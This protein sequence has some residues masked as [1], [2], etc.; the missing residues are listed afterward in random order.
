[1]WY[2]K[3]SC[4]VFIS[5]THLHGKTRHERSPHARQSQCH[6]FSLISRCGPSLCECPRAT[7]TEKLFVSWLMFYSCSHTDGFHLLFSPHSLSNSSIP[8]KPYAMVSDNFN[9]AWSGL[10]SCKNFNT[11][12]SPSTSVF[13]SLQNQAVFLPL[14]ARYGQVK[15]RKEYSS[16]FSVYLE[17]SSG[18]A[19][20]KKRFF[21]AYECTVW[22]RNAGVLGSGD[23]EDRMDLWCSSDQNH[24]KLWKSGLCPCLSQVRG[25]LTTGRCSP[26]LLYCSKENKLLYLEEQMVCTFNI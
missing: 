23:Y 5:Q 8:K 25:A 9:G 22:Y 2:C 13:Q 26:S 10:C 12:F 6:D 1:M 7:C 17:L 24:S 3:C 21:S 19:K 11:S 15:K 18:T 14:L 20:K 16:L 4:K